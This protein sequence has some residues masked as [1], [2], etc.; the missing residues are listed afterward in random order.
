MKLT[1]AA[2]SYLSVIDVILPYLIAEDLQVVIV[3][4]AVG[5]CEY[6]VENNCGDV[7]YFDI[8]SNSKQAT[9]DLHSPHA[10]SIW[11]LHDAIANK[12]QWIADN[13]PEKEFISIEY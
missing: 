12:L 8:T 13:L 7:V 2:N 1:F 11:D 5:Y 10:D 9:I 3:D 4:A 6:Q